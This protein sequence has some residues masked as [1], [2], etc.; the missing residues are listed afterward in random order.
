MPEGGAIVPK[1]TWTSESKSRLPDYLTLKHHKP[2]PPISNLLISE[3]ILDRQHNTDM[4]DHSEWPQLFIQNNYFEKL[5]KR[6][7]T[8]LSSHICLKKQFL[9]QDCQ[10]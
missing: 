3:K 4:D 7:F 5:L 1:L 8:K 9:H 2:N 10:L 6:L